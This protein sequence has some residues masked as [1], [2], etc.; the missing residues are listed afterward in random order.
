[1]CQILYDDVL[2][3]WKDIYSVWSCKVTPIGLLDV[4]E[5]KYMILTIHAV[6]SKHRVFFID[7]HLIVSMINRI[8]RQKF[9]S[10]SSHAEYRRNL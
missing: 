2:R 8:D 7:L 6:G 4:R 5:P 9:V 1:M 10:Y 3:K